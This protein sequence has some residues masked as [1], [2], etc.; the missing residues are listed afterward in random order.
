MISLFAKANKGGV[1]KGINFR[2]IITVVMVAVLGLVSLAGAEYSGFKYSEE[3]AQLYRM[4]I[5]QITPKDGILTGHVIA[6]GHY[7]KAPYKIEVKDTMV[8]INNVQVYPALKTPG[9]IEKEKKDEEERQAREK[10][11][12]EYIKTHQDEYNEMQRIDSVAKVLYEKEKVSKGKEAAVNAVAEIYRKSIGV[13]SVRVFGPNSGGLLVCYSPGT[14]QYELLRL[15][16]FSRPTHRFLDFEPPGICGPNPPLYKT[17]E[18]RDADMERM[19]FP[20]TKQGWAELWAERYE[21]KLQEGWVQTFYPHPS[22]SG[23]GFPNDAVLFE[24]FEI[25]GDKKKTQYEKY[26]ALKELRR[27]TFMHRAVL[28]FLSNFEAQEWKHLRRQK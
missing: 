4:P 25:I 22:G 2:G 7:M 11:V 16:G 1:M 17:Q 19:G 23:G 6:Y 14:I 15:D 12:A 21:E 28:I 24:I 3:E 20:T 5:E 18:E 27:G 9:M 8:F 10:T 26:E 13:D